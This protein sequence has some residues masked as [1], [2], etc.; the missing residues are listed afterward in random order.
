[1]NYFVPLQKIDKKDARMA[2]FSQVDRQIFRIALPAIISNITVPLLG[3]IDVAI[4]GH[5]GSPSYSGAIA[6]GSMLFNVV[7]WLFGFLRMGTSGMT[8]QAL[9]ARR[10]DEVMRL[11]LRSLLVALSVA[12]LIVVLQV[13]LRQLAFLLM[14]PSDD[15]GQF[16]STY[17]HIC[18]WGAP[19][20][21]CLYSLNGWFIGMQNSRIPM[22][23]AITQN[24]VNIA[25]SLFF[26]YGLGMKVE[27]VA[28][29]TLVAQYVGLLLALC[30]WNRYYGRLRPHYSSQGLFAKDSLTRFFRVNSDIF[31]RT[32]FLVAVNLFITSAGSWQ[33]E[34]ILAVNALLMQF[35]L[36]YSYFMDGFAY[37]GEAICGRAFGA[38]NQH[39]YRRTLR[40]LFAWSILLS[41]F[42]IIA[43][44][45]GGDNFVAVLTDQMHVRRLAQSYFIWVIC[46]PVVGMAAFLWDGIFIGI[47]ATRQMLVSTFISAVVFFLFY[48]L[49][50]ALFSL[51]T[52]H[53]LWLA[54]TAFLLSRSV[55]Q[56]ILS[57]R[58]P[59]PW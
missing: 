30:L 5:L 20:A 53:S 42:F 18:V 55:V 24:V 58:I 50:P 47:T 38:R 44:L 52:N 22:T 45:I 27:G 23:I 10:L 51:S 48:Y 6:L 46:V 12:L 36:I 59:Y 26:V 11:L 39:F 29:G 49:S 31:L 54:F 34:Q 40:H 8:S 57:R 37:A 7:Y 56:T 21:L 25:A 41:L 15:V 28:Y 14:Q 4:V 16:A 17:Y 43:F 2:N 35:F 19:A 3:L 13:P 1:M 9:G 33:G 32:L